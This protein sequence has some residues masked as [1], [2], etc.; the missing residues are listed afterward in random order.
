M[1]DDSQH[2]P[3]HQKHVTKPAKRPYI[4]ELLNNKFAAISSFLSH[5]R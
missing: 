3:R 1:T 4:S 2:Q 5:S